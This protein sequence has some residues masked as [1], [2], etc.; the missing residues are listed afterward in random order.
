MSHKRFQVVGGHPELNHRYRSS[1]HPGDAGAQGR[2]PL[3]ARPPCSLWRGVLLASAPLTVQIPCKVDAGFHFT[4]PGPVSA[5]GRLTTS[6]GW[7]NLISTTHISIL[8]SNP[9]LSSKRSLRP[10]W[11]TRIRARSCQ[12]RGVALIPRTPLHPTVLLERPWP[13]DRLSLPCQ[14]HGRDAKDV[15][16]GVAAEIALNGVNWKSHRECRPPGR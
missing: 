3:D 6:A 1:L 12:M 2:T 13:C 11:R 10:L 15:D 14:N 9:S 4:D 8:L 16:G 7:W 5:L